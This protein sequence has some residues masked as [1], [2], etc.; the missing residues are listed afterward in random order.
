MEVMLMMSVLEYASDVSLDVEVI[1]KLCKKLGIN[2][3]GEDDIL[4]DDAIIMLDN[5]IENGNDVSDSDSIDDSIMD[6]D[7]GVI[8]KDIDKNVKKSNS[9]KK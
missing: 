4:D 5:E 7:E 6:N 8:E 1:L 3:S 2:V 9:A